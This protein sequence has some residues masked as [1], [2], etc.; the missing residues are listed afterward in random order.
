LGFRTKSRQRAM[1][2]VSQFA[3]VIFR[4][5]DYGGDLTKINFLCLALQNIQC[6]HHHSMS[7][8]CSIKLYINVQ[9]SWA[10]V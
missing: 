6:Y 10:S 4:I 3:A 8:Q 2:K 9:R 7:V 1:L 5:N